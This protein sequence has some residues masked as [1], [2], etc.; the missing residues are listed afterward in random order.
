MIVKDRSVALEHV[1]TWFMN[2]RELFTPRSG[3]AQPGGE[4][5]RKK[6]APLGPAGGDDLA[7]ECRRDRDLVADKSHTIHALG[8]WAIFLPVQCILVPGAL[9]WFADTRLP[10]P[11][12]RKT[13]HKKTFV[14][15]GSRE[16]PACCDAAGSAAVSLPPLL[17]TQGRRRRPPGL[18]RCW[19]D[20]RMSGAS[21]P[22]T[23]A[24]SCI[25]IEDDS[26]APPTAVQ[27]HRGWRV[28]SSRRCTS[29]TSQ[30]PDTQAA[31]HLPPPLPPAAAQLTAATAGAGAYMCQYN[32]REATAFD[33]KYHCWISSY[34][35][36]GSE[37]PAPQDRRRGSFELEPGQR[38]RRPAWWRDGAF[39]RAFLS[40]SAAGAA[41]ASR[42]ADFARVGGRAS[43]PSGIETINP[44]GWHPT[45]C[46]PAPSLPPQDYCGGIGT[47]PTRFN[48]SVLNLDLCPQDGPGARR[49]WEAAAHIN[50]PACSAK[51]DRRSKRLGG[52]KQSAGSRIRGAR[53]RMKGGHMKGAAASLRRSALSHFTCPP[54]LHRTLTHTQKRMC[55]GT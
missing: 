42:S 9:F 43:R 35:K 33:K 17:R 51:D 16:S 52:G 46:L 41:D 15:T 18:A 25:T 11:H 40:S 28:W 12:K 10:T 54:C 38:C 32:A 19:C 48:I 13:R 37:C 36:A 6:V 44:A 29:Q 39:R 50:A 7:G 22:C 55:A 20:M 14:Y 45:S 1:F 47:T 34:A 21:I 27:W 49:L 26:A 31:S 53:T 23:Y 2:P 3:T 4:G 24:S 30:H 5:P 8:C